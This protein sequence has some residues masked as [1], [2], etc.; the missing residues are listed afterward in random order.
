MLNRLFFFYAACF[1]CECVIC[2]AYMLNEWMNEWQCEINELRPE[3]D[4]NF[5][6]LSIKPQFFS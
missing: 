3:E 1:S 5:G 4:P 6:L 2:I